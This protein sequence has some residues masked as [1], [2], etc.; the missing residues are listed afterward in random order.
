[1]PI[2]DVE[3][4]KRSGQKFASGFTPGQKVGTALGVAVLV[5]GMFMFTKW[6]T[7]PDYAPLFTNLSSKDAGDI[8]KALG[9]MGVGYK[10]A[11]GG[12]TVMVPKAN[13]YQTRVNLS[14]K[15][16]P[17]N[18][19]GYALLDKQGI[20][21]SEFVQNVDYQRA[22]Q[23]ELANTIAAIHGISNA[24]VNLTIPSQD[25][26]VDATQ[27]EAK[28][29]VLIDTGSVRLGAEQVQ[30]IVHLVA[31]AVK[32]LTPDGI[33]VSDTN[34]NLLYSPGADATFASS[35]NLSRTLAYEATV[36][37]QIEDMITRSL[38]PGHA[39]VVVN[40]TLDFSQG[41]KESVTHQALVDK[42]GNPIQS[43]S[44][45][46]TIQ[47]NG[48]GAASTGILGPTGVPL[49]GGNN[50]TPNSYKENS[51]SANNVIDTTDTKTSN[52]TPTVTAQSVSVTLDQS[53]VKAADVAKWQTQ[54]AAAAGI[55]AA[56][57]D[58]LVVQTMPM[59]KTIQKQAQ[60]AFA[61]ATSPKAVA[62]P[63]DLMGIIRY[64]VTLLIVGLVLF[65]AWRSV[66]KAQSALAPVR[67]PIDLAALEAA[68]PIAY[69]NELATNLGA[70]LPQPERR[71][72][73]PSRSPIET[74]V[75]ELIERQP[76]DVAQTLRSWLADR[77]A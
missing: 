58:T 59:D 8:T 32:G 27:Q 76:E 70:E 45:S 29:S 66:R 72:L 50:T 6:T 2:I 73:E 42:K 51:T 18:T 65:F 61:N 69:A 5:L 57:G 26:F 49:T 25:P 23:T 11:D 64:A 48:S 46:H 68:N 60:T 17:A 77:R 7:A 43:D 47:Y 36:K 62:T 9:T 19:D 56:R 15:G 39:A 31:S 35:Q 71:S 52:S 53:L 63:L 16:L 30:S 21:T 3:R 10:L 14:S 74:E 1:M 67:V 44:Q 4:M 75:V 22:V 12:S 34:G 40:A 33:T 38:G 20:T 37:Q 55:L 28:A 24:T 54:L 13:L 41:T